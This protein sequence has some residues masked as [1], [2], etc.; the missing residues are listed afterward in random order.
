MD[1]V[2]EA[3]DV[4]IHSVGFH[5][6][7]QAQ[8]PSTLETGWGYLSC[9]DTAWERKTGDPTFRNGQSQQSDTDNNGNKRKKKERSF[10]L[11]GQRCYVHQDKQQMM[12]MMMMMMISPV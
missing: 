10:P 12:M 3:P 11:C 8:D 5:N 7:H 2:E 9:K 1:V 6:W 4:I